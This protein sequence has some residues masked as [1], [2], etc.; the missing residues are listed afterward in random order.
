MRKSG[1]EE[2]KKLYAINNFIIDFRQY[3]A[4]EKFHSNFRNHRTFSNYDLSIFLEIVN[5]VYGDD[6]EN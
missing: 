2:K 4:L 5:D 6:I 1:D 3:V